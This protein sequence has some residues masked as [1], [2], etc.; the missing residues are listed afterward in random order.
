MAGPGRSR[1]APGEPRREPRL[2]RATLEAVRRREG[3][4][5]EALFDLEFERIH[6]LAWRLTGD[7]TA[8]EDIVQEAFLRVH[9][10]A[11][12]LDPAR[13]P[14]PWI[15]TIT[16]N[17]CRER[18][19]SARLRLARRTRSLDGEDELAGRLPDDGADPEQDAV[20]ADRQR[21]LRAALDGLPEPQR[22]VVVLH[23]LEGLTHEEVADVLDARPAAVR[24]RHS[25][26]LAALRETLG[27][28]LA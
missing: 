4:A 2:P 9:R 13:D 10:A 25:R 12:R 5:L 1:G 14:G 19:R 22:L 17:L 11:D 27:D 16:C 7:R 20:A 23:D 18:H 6:R 28:L 3:W 26:A 15:T 24:K 8:A 21:R